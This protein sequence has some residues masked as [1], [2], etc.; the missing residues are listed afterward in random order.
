MTVRRRTTATRQQSSK[1]VLVVDGLS[2]ESY[3]ENFVGMN[4][5]LKVI[6]KPITNQSSYDK[7]LRHCD[8][9]INSKV[10]ELRKKDRLVIV[11]DVDNASH[12]SVSRFERK[13]TEKGYQLYISNICFEVWLLMHYRNITRWYT[14]EELNKELSQILGRE[15]VKSDGI[16]FDESKVRQAIARGYELIPEANDCIKQCLGLSKSSTTLHFLVEELID[17]N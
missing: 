9:M 17:N 7:T 3:F 16:P 8:R 6:L 10:V 4:P 13:C 15:Y 14:T 2:E 1:I 11:T 12:E 5:N